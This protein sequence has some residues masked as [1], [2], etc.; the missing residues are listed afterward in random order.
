MKIIGLTGSIGMG[1]STIAAMFA[2]E[3]VPVFD[4]DAEVHELQ[5]PGGKALAA[6]EQAF[7][8]VTHAAGLDRTALG[9]AVFGKPEELK[10]LERIVH[11]LVAERQAAFLRRHR[12]SR[13]PFVILDIPLLFERGGWQRV[14]GIIVVSAPHRV[15]RA[16][17]LARPGMTAEKFAAIRAS[18]TP[19]REKRA[20]ADW[21]IETG[22]GKRRSLRAVRRLTACLSRAGVRY[23]RQCVK[24]SS[25]PKRRVSTPKTATGSAK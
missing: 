13:T 1:K 17:V 3:G 21:V 19:D 18:Q 6:I 7:P 15:Q 14:D 25:T 22:L 16:R 11:P 12:Q 10:K 8:G 2:H 5:G 9:K 20:R 24:L 4:A 23:C